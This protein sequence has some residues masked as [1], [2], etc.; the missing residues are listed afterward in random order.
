V[1]RTPFLLAFG[2]AASAL[3]FTPG[4]QARGW[5]E[6][7]QTSDDVRLTVG[8]DGV[9]TVQHHL[10]Y[11]VV[12]GHFK[13]LDFTGIE[14]N[15]E[16]VSETTALMEKGGE[17]PAHILVN[18]KVPG[19]L[20]IG[21]DEPRGIGRGVYVID[22]KY[23]LDLVAAKML[24][25]DGAMWRLAW[26]A[27]V[28]PEGH[29][30]AR[31]VFEVPSA[32]TEPRLASPEQAAT[33]L[34]T[35]RR[36]PEKDELELV[37]A[38]IPRGEAVVWSAR[39]DPKAFPRV[40][41]PEL[42]PPVAAVTAAAPVPNHVPAVLVA[43]VL[44]VLAGALAFALGAK[45]RFVE[46]AC[47]SAS[48]PVRPRPLVPLRWGL[49]PFAYGASAVGGLAE[50]LWG[51]PAYGALL[52]VVAMA[53]AAH[54]AP[55]PIVRPRGPG[56][57]QPISDGAV[58]VAR[59]RESA[60]GDSF[61]IGTRAGKLTALGLVALLAL[62][63]FVLRTRVAGA[64]ISIPLVAA[65]LVPLFATGTHAQQPRSPA[66]LA[67]RVLG[68]ARDMLGRLVDF[69]HVDVR[70]LARFRE[71]TQSYDEV[72]LACSPADRIPGL[73]SIEL[74]LATLEPG[75]PAA[76]PEVLV[77]FDDGSQAASKIAQLA[78]GIRVVT[79]RGPDEKVLRLTP[80][81]PTPAG[82]ARLLARLASELEGRRATD[83][84]SSGA[85]STAAPKSP[86]R[87][88]TGVDRRVARPRPVSA[89]TARQTLA[90]A[91]F[92]GVAATA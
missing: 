50:L 49:A 45:Q 52:V 83:R 68:P 41:S 89:P 44:A 60:P 26:T 79:G 77:R 54:R 24:V 42:R 40:V 78:P 59:P 74:A 43:C 76:L 85:D 57:W 37:R 27:P 39:V 67:A 17:L 2:L 73:R 84:V 91:A 75:A 13:T 22:V 55:A 69:A 47:A 19:G 72:R 4:V 20:L 8:A 10:R 5:E 6:V 3:A 51:T 35:L 23:R 1:P 88:F 62:A 81:A 90:P 56:R 48:T 29:D 33:T 28:S 21:F 36:E 71:G 34:A 70:C 63:S 14:P 82:A 11:R 15:A 92:G 18:P 61:D 9:A 16:L 46:R 32:P 38:H 12:A 87:G 66:E 58:L 30:G 7:H 80:R 25:R 31:V 86:S 64:A 53:F 65:A